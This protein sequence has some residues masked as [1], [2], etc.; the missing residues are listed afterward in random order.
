MGGYIPSSYY[1][2]V[3]EMFWRNVVSI[4]LALIGFFYTSSVREV[5]KWLSQQLH[6]L[7]MYC[8]SDCRQ[9]STLYV[10]ISAAPI[11]TFIVDTQQYNEY[12]TTSNARQPTTVCIQCSKY[13]EGKRKGEYTMLFNLV[14]KGS[15]SWEQTTHKELTKLDKFLIAVFKRYGWQHINDGPNRTIPLISQ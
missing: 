15:S 12:Q 1:R 2:T 6:V 3:T 14:C 8:Y 4:F 7:Q 5:S 10:N 13:E 11:S 9:K